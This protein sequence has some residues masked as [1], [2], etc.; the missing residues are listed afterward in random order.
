[1]Y[2]FAIACFTHFLVL[3]FCSSYFEKASLAY[4]VARFLACS[5]TIILLYNACCTFFCAFLCVIFNC[6][7]FGA[8]F[9]VFFFSNNLSYSLL[10]ACFFVRVHLQQPLLH[11]ACCTF[12]APFCNNLSCT[13]FGAH[14]LNVLLCS[15]LFYTLFSAPLFCVFLCENLS[16]T[17]FV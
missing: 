6:K 17:L 9:L 2:F 16:C 4:F 10:I 14:F 8:R 3:D 1:M 11:T 15:N 12:L 13:L 5:C 7:L